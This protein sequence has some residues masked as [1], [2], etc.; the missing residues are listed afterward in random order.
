MFMHRNI[1]VRKI[2]YLACL[3]YISYNGDVISYFNPL[4]NLHCK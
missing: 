4:K 1:G 2:S 3:M